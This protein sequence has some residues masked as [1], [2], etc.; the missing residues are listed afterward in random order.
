MAEIIHS[1]GEAGGYLVGNRHTE[2]GI[3][4]INKSTGQPLEMEGG[5]VVITRN[6][7]SDTTKRSFNG[8]MMTNRE[9]LSSINKSG[10]G[11]EFAEGGELPATIDF[12]EA[13][14]QYEGETVDASRV[15][16]KM[17]VGGLV[18]D[19]LDDLKDIYDQGGQVPYEIIELLSINSGLNWQNLTIVP[20]N[21]D[22]T[23]DTNRERLIIDLDEDVLDALSEEDLVKI[24]LA[25][26]GT[27][28]AIGQLLTQKGITQAGSAPQ[29]EPRRQLKQNFTFEFVDSIGQ[30]REISIKSLLDVPSTI[31]GRMPEFSG[32]IYKIRGNLTLNTDG[33][34]QYVTGVVEY[35][36]SDVD[37]L[38]Y[39]GLKDSLAIEFEKNSLFTQAFQD[40]Y[41]EANKVYCL[42]L[43]GRIYTN[44][45][46]LVSR[47]TSFVTNVV[48][49]YDTDIS[50]L[51]SF[52][53]LLSSP[54]TNSNN[55]AIFE[56]ISKTLTTNKVTKLGLQFII[57]V[58][59][60]SNGGNRYFYSTN[61]VETDN[62]VNVKGASKKWDWWK[63]NIFG[64][65]GFS[66]K[67]DSLLF[68]NFL[69][70]IDFGPFECDKIF[71]VG[72]KRSVAQ[73]K[74]R[75]DLIVTN[76][77]N[78]DKVFIQNNTGSK[79]GEIGFPPF[80]IEIYTTGGKFDNYLYLEYDTLNLG[81]V[82][83][84]I[85]FDQEVPL[86]IGEKGIFHFGYQNNVIFTFD[87]EQAERKKLERAELARLEKEKRAE[88]RKQLEEEQRLEEEKQLAFKN[89]PFKV[90]DQQKDIDLFPIQAAKGAF[91]DEIDALRVLLQ[92]TDN[93]KMRDDR[94][95][96]IQRI[97]ALERKDLKLAFKE[98]L[99]KPGETLASPENMLD[100]YFNQATQ[101]PVVQIGEPC[102]LITPTGVPSKL[103]IQSYEAVRTSYFKAWF[104]DW[105]EAYYSGEKGVS[106]VLVD[107]ETA[108]PKIMYHG[109]RQFL[110]NVRVGNMGEG[111]KRPYATFSQSRFP[112]SYFGD[113][114]DYVKFYAGMAKNQPR[115]TPNYEG[116]I[117][118]VF[119]KLLNPVVLSGLGMESS[120]D[121]LIAYISI[122]YAINIEPSV[123]IMEELGDSNRPFKVWNIIR[124]DIN[125][126]ETLKTAG[127]D[128]IIQL[129]DVPAFDE[130]GMQ[131]EDT[132]KGTEYLI[133]DGGQIKDASVKN[134]FYLPEFTDIRFKQGGNVRI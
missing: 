34:D 45:E 43:N 111:V 25:A 11:V 87:Q 108:E 24:D 74:A 120:Y 110:E 67:S 8:K 125:L 70:V 57:K 119:I 35:N 17:A 72:A 112:A 128:G 134:S 65:K 42:E 83:K 88:E 47:N 29:L 105:E 63:T 22:G 20:K 7:V 129:G 50:T 26:N 115:A 6:A 41:N 93:E 84:D 109:V 12:I 16:E 44:D 114:L 15:L 104:G 75:E 33:V 49:P 133:F 69:D 46:P 62:F 113:N 56:K 106:S 48:Y 66:Y 118:C 127:Y 121:D 53:P 10:G 126:I 89:R 122:N 92:F 55:F 131:Q 97:S 54:L 4:A 85:R 98:L 3:K 59:N 91:Q 101:S 107:E 13:V 76:G 103:P 19:I 78:A 1:K 123:D 116:F 5:E 58:Q 94:A 32:G 71:R 96:I 80:K 79:Y 81:Q 130:N 14:I 100:Y 31:E 124:K 37:L 60:A 18:N 36:V 40:L 51:G 99:R 30:A 21:Q 39:S 132:L 68:A 27:N 28:Q 52:K 38:T 9:I 61:F 82:I 117:Y 64:K 77:P 86:Y 73:K 2:G 23:F 102:G 90:R 95:K